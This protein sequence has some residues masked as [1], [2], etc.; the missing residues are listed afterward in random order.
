[1][2]SVGLIPR[3]YYDHGACVVFRIAGGGP[4]SPLLSSPVGVAARLQVRA[5]PGEPRSF[6]GNSPPALWLPG[7]SLFLTCGM[8]FAAV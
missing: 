8:E 6:R 4:S 7:L 2:P 1:M 3:F 5:L